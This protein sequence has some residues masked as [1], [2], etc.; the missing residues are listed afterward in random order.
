[1][2]DS[3]KYAGVDVH[4]ASCRFHVRSNGG[5]R[6]LECTVPTTETAIL[7]LLRSI[8]GRIVVAFE[9]GSQSEWLYRLLRPVVAEVIVCNARE[10]RSGRGKSKSDKIDAEQLSLWLYK[11][12]LKPVYHEDHGTGRLRH[13]VH[14]Y[15]QLVSDRSRSKNRLKAIYH[16]RA[17]GVRGAAVYG[18]ARR[19]QWMAQL[20]DDG[21]RTRARLLVEQIDQVKKLITEAKREMVAEV[22]THPAYLA[23][24]SIPGIGDVRASQLI[25]TIRTPMRFRRNRQLWAYG[26]LAVVMD[27]S[28]E[29]EYVDGRP[30][31]RKGAS[32]TR[33]LTK[34][35][36]H[37]VKSALKGA[38]MTAAS[39]GG[40]KP[41]YDRL[42]A[43]NLAPELAR[44]TLARKIATLV[45]VLWKKGERFDV[46]KLENKTV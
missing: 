20:P 28:G 23:L 12:V 44:V 45:L 16:S 26:G 15:E 31:R 6:E 36:N 24:T 30:Q 9:E 21:A 2:K 42:L 35:C 43:R 22:R 4:P 14:I 40:L 11:G 1:M 37:R 7:E 27:G 5:R 29:I 25:A 10:N 39:S 46:A 34:S 8:G 32:R 19:G 38:A 41:Y 33:G 17:I 18:A 3:T 13:L